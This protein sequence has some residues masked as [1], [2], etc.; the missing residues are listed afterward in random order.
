MFRIKQVLSDLPAST[1]IQLIGNQLDVLIDHIPDAVDIVDL[2]GTILKINR[3]FEIMYGWTAK[4]IVGKRLPIIPLDLLGEGESLHDVVKKGNRIMGYE[5]TRIRKDG[6]VIPI[7]LTISPLVDADGFVCGHVA[8][9]RDMTDQKRKMTY[10]AT[11]DQLTGLPNRSYFYQLAQRALDESKEDDQCWL[12]ILFNLDGFTIINDALGQSTGDDLL[13]QVAS[14]LALLAEKPAI[15]ARMGNDEFALFCR[16]DHP[17][18]DIHR[19]M[20]GIHAIFHTPFSLSNNQEVIIAASIGGSVYPRNGRSVEGLLQKA[21]AAMNGVKRKGGNGYSLYQPRLQTK[22]TKQYLLGQDLWKATERGEMEL[23]YQP[24]I[25]ISTGAISGFEALLRWRHPHKGWILPSL[26]IPLAEELELIDSLG[27]WVLRRACAD[28]KRLQQPGR[29]PFKVAV[30]LSAVQL[31]DKGFTRKLQG[32]LRETG[33]DARLLELEI[34]ESGII[35][36]TEDTVNMLNEIRGMGVQISIDDFGTGFASLDYVKRFPVDNVKIDKSFI[37]SENRQDIAIVKG[38]M[39]IAQHLGLRVI[40]EGVESM[41]HLDF[42]RRHHCDMFQGY[43][44]SPALPFDRISQFIASYQ[45]L[46]D[47]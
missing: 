33:L 5:T 45:G 20:D 26:F 44:A 9:S 24:M 25:E 3:S 10:L 36:N 41:E 7:L 18:R 11:H 1:N 16:I 15:V 40:A 42:L 46:H 14:R 39:T 31:R 29:N 47:H 32:I 38:I 28:I 23:F 27:I 34:T 13:A 43:L 22:C 30:N 8:I 21:Y 19:H 4:E 35:S 12:V 6:T 2:N 17:S 37:Q